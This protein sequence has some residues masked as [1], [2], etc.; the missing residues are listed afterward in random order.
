MFAYR[1]IEAIHHYIDPNEEPNS[2]EERMAWKQMRLILNIDQDTSV[3]DDSSFL[4][5]LR[6]RA[7]KSRHDVLSIPTKSEYHK[8]LETAKSVIE[9]FVAYDVTQ[10]MEQPLSKAEF[11]FLQERMK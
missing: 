8:A 2:R 6:E 4:Y 1:A 7:K 10:P 5:W 9:R 11:P 3:F